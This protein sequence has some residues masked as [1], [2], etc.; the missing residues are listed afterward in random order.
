MT[1]SIPADPSAAPWAE[2]RTLLDLED[3]VPDDPMVMDA[4]TRMLTHPLVLGLVAELQNWPGAVLNSH[5]NAGLPYHKLAFLAD[6]G[7]T[8]K[9]VELSAVRAAMDEHRM[10]DGLLRIP[11]NIPVHF[12]GTGR[13]LWGW[14]LCDV[15]VQLYGAIGTG[16]YTSTEMESAVAGLIQLAAGNGWPCAG[17]GELGGFRGPGRKTDP[18]PFATL[19]M[20]RLLTLFPDLQ[21]GPA[22]NAGTESLL[23]L[24]NR[25]REEHPYLFHMGTDFRKIKAPMIW[26]DLIHVL[27]V[28]TQYPGIR[29]DPRFLDM[30]GV[31]E[32]K[33]DDTGR[34]TAESVWTAWKDWDFGQKKIPSPWI[35]LLAHRIVRRSGI[36]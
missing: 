25:S 2:Y 29:K 20:L 34:F 16:L 31:M 24:W 9:D 5:K 22:V 26:Y 1:V 17:S 36:G 32:S 28:L 30:L 4:K 15:P 27:D 21:D 12:G 35:T 18:C 13:D 8:A 11:I 6:I 23:H 7:V 3:R 10:E 14:S 19:S 33:A